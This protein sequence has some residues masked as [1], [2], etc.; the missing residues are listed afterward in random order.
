MFASVF[1][2]GTQIVAV[3]GIPFEE[4]VQRSSWEG[5]LD[6]AGVDADRD[7]IFAVSGMEVRRRMIV[8]QQKD[9]NS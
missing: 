8:V 4:Q 5:S 3:K 1:P 7:F 6:N 9:D 2:V